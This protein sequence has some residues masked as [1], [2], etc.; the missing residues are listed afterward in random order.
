MAAAPGRK[1]TGEGVLGAWDPPTPPL[2][3][4]APLHRGL[5]RTLIHQTRPQDRLIHQGT[6]DSPH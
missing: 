3:A 1:V 2:L 6:P 5:G 4:Q